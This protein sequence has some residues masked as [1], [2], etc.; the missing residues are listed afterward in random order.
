MIIVLLDT[1][2]EII[3]YYFI[4]FQPVWSHH[5]SLKCAIGSCQTSSL[6][7]LETVHPKMH[8]T[9][10]LQMYPKAS[11]AVGTKCGSLTGQSQIL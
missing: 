6:N 7:V 4:I 1:V 5:Q 3:V 8:L 11:M 9:A 2:R 10:K